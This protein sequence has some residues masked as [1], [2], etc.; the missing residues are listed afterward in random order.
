MKPKVKSKFL[1]LNLLFWFLLCGWAQ[2]QD[3]CQCLDLDCQQDTCLLGY[4]FGELSDMVVVSP[5]FRKALDEDFLLVR[6]E[7][8][9]RILVYLAFLE[10]TGFIYDFKCKGCEDTQVEWEIRKIMSL[11]KFTPPT[12]YAASSLLY[13]CIIFFQLQPKGD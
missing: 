4:Q 9:Y 8:E 1:V 13:Q 11:S 12:K 6:K 3:Y 7:G 10:G 5:N 2:A